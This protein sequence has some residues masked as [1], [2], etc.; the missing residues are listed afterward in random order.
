MQ[1]IRDK[2]TLED[3]KKMSE[4]MYDSLVKAVVDVAQHVMVVDAALHSDEEFF[5]LE[6]GSKQEDLWG[7]NIYPYKWGGSEE[8]VFDSMINL[9]PRQNNRSRNVEDPLIREQIVKIVY[10]LVKTS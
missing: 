2:I 9:R 3:L 1:L 7:I 5:L 4:N 10:G 6:N 8:I